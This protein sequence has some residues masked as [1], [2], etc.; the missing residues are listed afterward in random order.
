MATA[1]LRERTARSIRSG[2][3][4]SQ[5]AAHDFDRQ[6]FGAALPPRLM[7][8][9]IRRICERLSGP[10]APRLSAHDCASQACLSFSR[11]MHL[12]SGEV[13][14]TFRR[15]RAWKRARSLLAMMGGEPSLVDVALDAGYADSTHF[16]RSVRRCYGYT[17]SAMFD[18]SRRLSVIAQVGAQA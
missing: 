18:G 3:E 12:F 7:D 1:S 6:Y 11:F 13:H 2:F 9:R 16:S 8:A 10:A 17:P 14:T 5:G 15:Y 4:Q